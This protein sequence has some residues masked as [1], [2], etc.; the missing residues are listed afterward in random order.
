M[1]DDS[2]VEENAERIRTNAERVLQS[3]K[4]AFE[5]VGRV[6]KIVSTNQ[7]TEPVFKTEMEKA[8]YNDFLDDLDGYEEALRKH[9]NEIYIY[10]KILEEIKYLK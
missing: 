1:A 8:I 9:S 6:Y 4:D 3:S 7:F 2:E 5:S 10:T